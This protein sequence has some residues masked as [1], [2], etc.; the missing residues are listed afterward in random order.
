MPEDKW[1]VGD[2][3]TGGYGHSLSARVLDSARNVLELLSKNRLSK[4]EAILIIGTL[5]KTCFPFVTLSTRNFLEE[6]M[7]ELRL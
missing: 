7:R 1:D 4:R 5:E 6:T 2:S 3:E